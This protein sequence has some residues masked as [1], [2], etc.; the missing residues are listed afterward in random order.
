MMAERRTLEVTRL[1][2]LARLDPK[3]EEAQSF[4]VVRCLNVVWRAPSHLRGWALHKLAF[5]CKD[6]LILELNLDRVRPH[7]FFSSGPPGSKVIMTP[8]R[9][10]RALNDLTFVIES[11]C[12]VRGSKTR[13]LITA[14]RMPR[15]VW[16]GVRHPHDYDEHTVVTLPL[17]FPRFRDRFYPRME[18]EGHTIEPRVLELIRTFVVWKLTPNWWCKSCGRMHQGTHRLM[19][20]KRLGW[21][22]I[23]MRIFRCWWYNT[24]PDLSVYHRFDWSKETQC[25]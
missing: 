11:S 21:E 6:E 13:S 3:K 9:M 5:L 8:L 1:D 23:D 20:A 16:D 7:K 2:Q 22:T 25:M 10:E 17:T 24:E 12:K 19:V 18:K 4:D 15:V 14:R